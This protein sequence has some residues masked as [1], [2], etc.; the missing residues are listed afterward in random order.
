MNCRR[1]SLWR[2]QA[3]QNSDAR[4]QL[5][6][7]PSNAIFSLYQKKEETIKSQKEDNMDNI[8]SIGIVVVLAVCLVAAGLCVGAFIC[9]HWFG[10][11]EIAAVTAALVG[12]GK[13]WAQFVFIVCVCFNFVSWILRRIKWKRTKLSARKQKGNLYEQLTL[14]NSTDVSDMEIL[15]D[16]F[17]PVKK[18][19][20]VVKRHF[21]IFC[22]VPILLASMQFG[23]E[24][25]SAIF[26]TLLG[27]NAAYEITMA[28]EEHKT[29]KEDEKKQTE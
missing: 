10:I 25:A 28:L 4:I 14:P 9:R 13:D 16:A 24:T 5:F 21:L 3:E 15:K 8:K 27:A 22:S 26:I 7:F 20:A 23:S 6:C 19:F 2:N 1:Y 12:A 29:R 11:F 18:A 17:M